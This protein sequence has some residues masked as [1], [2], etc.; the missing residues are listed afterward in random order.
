MSTSHARN[1]GT[2]LKTE[3]FDDINVNRSALERRAA[4]I[5]ARRSVK[6]E[7]QAAWLVRAIQ[8]IDLTTL[9]GDDTAGRVRRLCAKA[10]NPIRA[11]IL[12]G[13]GL[14]DANITTGA[15]CVYPTMVPHAVKALEGTNIPVASVATG[16][17]AGLIPLPLRLAEIRYA[18]EEG[19]KEIDIVITREHV[20]TQNWQALY[21][22]MAA[23]REACGEAHMKAILATGD[24]Q[25]LTNVYKASMVAMQA[26]SDFIKTSTGK[27]EVNAT[28]PVSLTMV[29]ALRDYG[30]LTG[31]IIGFKPAGGLRTAKEALVW[32]S[33]M[34]EELGHDWLQ[35][36]LFRIGASSLLG[37]IERQ[38]EHY[39]TG[40][41][42]DLSRHAAA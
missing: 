6:K 1:T 10:K 34:K 13:L 14:A 12:E 17:P 19:A 11:D 36:D 18:V 2:P 9:A 27:E 3:W 39:V 41:Y 5:P 42:A 29:R 33:M 28:L 4:T 24:L 40:R 7:Y 35:P 20:L 22:E 8:C 15:V 31:Q 32:L 30:E 26:G 25:T 21:D 38:L 23:M 16:F 37:D